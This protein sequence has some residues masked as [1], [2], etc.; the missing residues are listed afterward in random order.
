MSASSKPKEPK[1]GTVLSACAVERAAVFELVREAGARADDITGPDGLPKSITATVLEAALEEEINEHLGDARHQVPTEG[2]GNIR[3][4]K[5][6][7][8]PG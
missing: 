7:G 5:W 3:S 2:G 4:G 8:A 6:D 1:K